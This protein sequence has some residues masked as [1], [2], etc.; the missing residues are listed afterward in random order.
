M[1]YNRSKVFFL[2]Y[3]FLVWFGFS[4][5][6]MAVQELVI[7]NQTSVATSNEGKIFQ[8]IGENIEFSKNINLTWTSCKP[9]IRKIFNSRNYFNSWIRVWRKLL[10]W[11]NRIFWR[12]N[13]DSKQY[14]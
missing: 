10:K 2:F 13:F 14:F 11:L 9:K 6:N 12:W 5:K 4:R 3:F 7:L 8:K 1:Q